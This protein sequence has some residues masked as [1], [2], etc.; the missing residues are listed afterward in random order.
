MC[1]FPA[2]A[3]MRIGAGAGR[4][5]G[6]VSVRPAADGGA[7]GVEAGKADRHGA[8][9]PTLRRVAAGGARMIVE[10]GR[11]KQASAHRVFTD[12]AV[13]LSWGRS[14]P[15]SRRRRKGSQW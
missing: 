10:V 5:L 9:R 6:W 14:W 7:E 4:G 11:G 8:G 13:Q 12:V 2:A 1:G 3:A 15:A